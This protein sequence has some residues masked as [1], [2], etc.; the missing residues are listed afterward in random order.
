MDVIPS[1]TVSKDWSANLRQKDPAGWQKLQDVKASL[2]QTRSAMRNSVK[3]AASQ[4]KA[5][6]QQTIARLKEAIKAL[7]NTPALDPKSMAR[8]LKM[9]SQQ[10]AAAVKDYAAASKALGENGTAVSAS[11]DTSVPDQ[12]DSAD[13]DIADEADTDA[14]ATPPELSQKAAQAYGQTQN[15]PTTDN[16]DKADRAFYKD[17]KLLLDEMRLLA[18]WQKRR[19]QMQGGNAFDQRDAKAAEQSLGEAQKSLQSLGIG[20]SVSA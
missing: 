14:T 4:R 7:R 8:M 3:T 19:I 9:L 16:D 15:R 11:V 6:A 18:R 20:N 1:I 12:I 17:A 2:Q 10:L 13:D 5:M